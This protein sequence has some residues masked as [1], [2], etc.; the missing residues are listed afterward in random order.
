MPDLTLD[1]KNI[2]RY[3]DFPLKI[4]TIGFRPTNTWV[5]RHH[6][7]RRFFLCFVLKAEDPEYITKIDGKVMIRNHTPHMEL[8]PPGVVLD[9]FRPNC[10]EELFFV[11]APENA[12][13][14]DLF[15]LHSCDFE[16]TPAFNDTLQRI[17]N[18]FSA[19]QCPG[20]ADRLDLLA[21]ELAQEAMIAAVSKT[22]GKGEMPDERIF[23]ISNYFQLH[24]SEHINLEGVLKKH[25]LTR[26]TFY[27]EWKKYYTVSPAQY[28][29]DLRLK[30]ACEELLH[31]RKK[32][33][34]IALD[35]GFCDPMYFNHC[36][37]RHYGCSP[38]VFR[39]EHLIAD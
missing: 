19:L 9:S 17:K 8:L 37:T 12:P 10:R 22:P 4:E 27:R 31:S 33:Y 3:L 20:M 1:L 32:I 13:A 18:N 6:R 15:K 7:L 36:F 29:I 26:R 11:Y 25:A 34:E 35:S 39:K 5:H 21:L 16:L 24:F 2:R 28:L 14:I 30:Y 38:Q 23:L